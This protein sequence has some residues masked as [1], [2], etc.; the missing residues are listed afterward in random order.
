MFK[1]T[2]LAVAATIA[3]GTAVLAPTTAASAHGFHGFHGGHHGWG[4]GWGR[5]W[6]GF[7]VTVVGPSCYEYQTVMTPRGPRTRLVNVCY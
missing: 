7:G 4:H 5:N 6:G 2:I 1:K 3:L